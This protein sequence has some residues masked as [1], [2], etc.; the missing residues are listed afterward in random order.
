[1]HPGERH[2]AEVT[3]RE[4]AEHGLQILEGTQHPPLDGPR[5]AQTQKGQ[6]D[7]EPRGRAKLRKRV[8]AHR[9]QELAP[10]ARLLVHDLVEDPPGRFELATLDSG[11]RERRTQTV[12][13]L[14][15]REAE[16]QPP[17]P[18]G[19]QL[20]SQLGEGDRVRLPGTRPLLGQQVLQQPAHLLEMGAVL[21]LD[22]DALELSGHAP[23]DAS[24]EEEPAE[25]DHREREEDRL[26]RVLQ[27]PSPDDVS[28]AAR[29]LLGR[30]ETVA[31]VGASQDGGNRL[32]PPCGI[33]V[34]RACGRPE[35]RGAS[36][37]GG[38]EQPSCQPP[39]SS[40]G[41]ERSARHPRAGARGRLV[42]IDPPEAHMHR[43]SRARS[44]RLRCGSFNPSPLPARPERVPVDGPRTT[45][46][47]GSRWNLRLHG[48]CGK[49][50]E[51]PVERLRGQ[52]DAA[53]PVRRRDAV[54]RIARADHQSGLGFGGPAWLP[55]RASIPAGLRSGGARKGPSGVSSGVPP[56]RKQR[57]T[58]PA[59][60]PGQQALQRSSREGGR[61]SRGF[62]ASGRQSA[63]GARGGGGGWAVVR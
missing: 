23:R 15:L 31:R 33:V 9:G 63:R 25:T 56:A 1:M 20:A 42:E 30:S 55:S 35:A 27:Q 44:M 3:G 4:L 34:E 16:V 43:V 6:R 52:A 32:P 5:A 46:A 13:V 41:R 58:A 60:T 11:A 14:A 59:T 2:R 39:G 19:S 47:S 50:L 51:P 18:H 40:E 62:G 49:A 22:L 61:G 21:H 8:C 7:E 28:S 38:E 10:G 53:N 17:R 12:Q 26:A 37:S 36:A 57:A 54:Q 24:Q 29:R 48:C 45:A